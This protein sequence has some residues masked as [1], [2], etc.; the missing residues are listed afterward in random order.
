MT[1]ELRVEC[2]HCAARLEVDGRTERVI[3]WR[4]PGQ[5]DGAGKAAPGEK[6][7]QRALERASGRAGQSAQRFE[8]ALEK[9]RRREADLEALFA[10]AKAKGSAAAP[11]APR[12]LDERQEPLWTLE[13]AALASLADRLAAAG[14]E[15]RQQDGFRGWRASAGWAWRLA[16]DLADPRAVPAPER[17][18]SLA[19]PVGFGPP[20][21]CAALREAGWWLAGF[22]AVWSL[23]LGLEAPAGG[24]GCRAPEPEELEAWGRGWLGAAPA[25]AAGLGGWQPRWLEKGAERRPAGLWLGGE[26]AVLGAPG[27][28]DSEW[29]QVARRLALA[30]GAVRLITE[31]EPLGPDPA[32]LGRLGWR[33]A[34]HRALF[35]APGLP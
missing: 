5:G 26:T 9:E 28:L 15:R 22:E 20:W 13:S 33:V 14:V 8:Q 10:R 23:E 32:S 31:S 21:D 6:D 17:G 30:A 16:G 3:R 34:Y 35:T 12:L 4:A 27:L 2:P 29:V 7:W 18:A 11:E 1:K 25:P 24:A 19:L